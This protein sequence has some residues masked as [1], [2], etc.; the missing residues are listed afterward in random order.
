MIPGA[1]AAL[2]GRAGS[3]P[4][5]TQFYK[6]PGHLI[7]PIGYSSARVSIIGEGGRGSYGPGA[8]AAFA[9]SV[10]AVAPGETL[11]VFKNSQDWHLRRAGSSLVKAEGGS[12]SPGLAANSIG[13]VRFSGGACGSSFGGG[14]GAAGPGGDGK[15]GGNGAS[16]FFGSDTFHAGGGG[17]GYGGGYGGDY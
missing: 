11:E 4:I 10:L 15:K 17:G 6:T 12:T 5:I 1:A 3:L 9:Q 13:N 8:G 2:G 16:G 14:G 7:V